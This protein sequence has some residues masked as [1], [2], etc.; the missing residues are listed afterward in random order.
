M[1]SDMEA[2]L[3]LV[4]PG[5]LLAQLVFL[6]LTTNR[7]PAESGQRQKVRLAARNFE[8]VQ[9]E[10]K[11][12]LRRTRCKLVTQRTRDVILSMQEVCSS[13]LYVFPFVFVS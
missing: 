9:V 13:F 11:L 5:V 8:A 6:Y 4:V 7:L 10:A 12:V 3:S 1:C 2:A